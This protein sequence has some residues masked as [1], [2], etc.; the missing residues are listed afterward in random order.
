[1]PYVEGPTCT[2]QIRLDNGLDGKI[3]FDSPLGIDSATQDRAINFLIRKLMR[4]Q[5]GDFSNLDLNIEL[6]WFG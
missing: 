3:T 6:H 5:N 1:M 2:Y 4:M